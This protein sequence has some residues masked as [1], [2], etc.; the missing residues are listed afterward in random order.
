[1]R[2]QASEKFLTRQAKRVG[3]FRLNITPEKV[4]RSDGFFIYVLNTH[5]FYCLD[6]L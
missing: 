1:M 4:I 5:G 6:Q 3:T 2:R